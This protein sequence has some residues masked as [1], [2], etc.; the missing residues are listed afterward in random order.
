ML[1][2]YKVRDEWSE[3]RSLDRRNK[4]DRNRTFHNSCAVSTDSGFEGF[5][6]AL[7][8]LCTWLQVPV[9]CFLDPHGYTSAFKL[10]HSR[11]IT[12]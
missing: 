10:T 2:R 7:G 9:F 4:R 3:G 11:N 5:V 12:W 1:H 6:W 8:V